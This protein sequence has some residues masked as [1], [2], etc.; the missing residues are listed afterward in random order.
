MKRVIAAVV[1]CTASAALADLNEVDNKKS[2]VVDCAKDPTIRVTGNQNTFTLKGTCASVQISGNQNTVKGDGAT[3]VMISGNDNTV[4][5]KAIDSAML[6]GNKNTVG[7]KK[8]PSVTDTG[9]GNKVT[10]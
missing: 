3:Q 5:L 1:L 9:E 7:A 8:R 6:T 10:P 4:A 2:H